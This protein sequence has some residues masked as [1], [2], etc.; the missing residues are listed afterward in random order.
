MKISKEEFCSWLLI[1]ITVTFMCLLLHGC[2]TTKYIPEYHERIVYK[3]DS[4]FHRDSLY[5]HDSIYIYRKGDTVFVNKYRLEY[6][7]VLQNKILKDS[8][9]IHDSIQSPPITKYVDKKLSK[10]ENIKMDIG[11]IAIGALLLFI[12]YFIVILWKKFNV[13]TIIKSIIK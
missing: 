3:T 2:S 10:W 9:F 12:I 13:T 8:I 6:K 1:A 5:T 11:G 4:V 7:D